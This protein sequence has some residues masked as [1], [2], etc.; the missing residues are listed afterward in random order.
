MPAPKRKWANEDGHHRIIVNRI[1]CRNCGD[2]IE[3]KYHHD[4][5]SCGCR[6]V[7]VDGGKSY[8]RRLWDDKLPDKTKIGFDEL[9]EF[10]KEDELPWPTQ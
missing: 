9:S 6:S 4:F 1:R 7:S 3:S 8:L 10:E 2:V 5:R